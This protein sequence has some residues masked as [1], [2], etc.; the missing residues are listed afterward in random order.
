MTD[1]TDLSQDCET[2]RHCPGNMRLHGDVGVDVDPPDYEQSSGS[3]V[4]VADPGWCL[5]Y[6]MLSSIRGAPEC[7]VAATVHRSA[8]YE[9]SMHLVY[10]CVY[11]VSTNSKICFTSR[12]INN[13]NRRCVV[14]FILLLEIVK[15]RSAAHLSVC[16]S[17]LFSSVNTVVIN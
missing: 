5:G 17:L 12:H 16:A 7:I 8:S 10:T 1:A 2:G 3:D 15:Q 13:A 4:V 9:H 14:K 6:Q 11:S